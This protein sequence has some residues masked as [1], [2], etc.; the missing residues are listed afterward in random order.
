MVCQLFRQFVPQLKLSFF[1][2]AG[3]RVLMEYSQPDENNILTLIHD[4]FT[5]KNPFKIRRSMMVSLGEIPDAIITAR[6]DI[7]IQIAHS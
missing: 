5:P 1:S 3:K 6:L 4:L 2:S 7:I